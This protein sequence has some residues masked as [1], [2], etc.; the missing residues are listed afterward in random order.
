MLRQ[1]APLAKA[2]AGTLLATLLSLLINVASSDVMALK[3]WSNWAIWLL[4]LLLV[5][6]SLLL[7]GQRH[8]RSTQ[9]DEASA[10]ALDWV[11][12]LEGS[13]RKRMIVRVRSSWMTDV[14][15][16]SL[17]A[18][19]RAAA[20]ARHPAALDGP[21]TPWNLVHVQRGMA[22]AIPADTPVVEVFDRKVGGAMLI[23]G[24]PGAGKTTLLFRLASDLLDAA[25]VDPA[26]AVPVVFK[27]A[28]WSPPRSLDDWLV[29]ELHKLYDVPS[30]LGRHWV[31]TEQVMPLLHGLDEVPFQDRARCV[32]AVNAYRDRHGMTS[33]AVT[34]RSAAYEQAARRLRVQGTIRVDPPTP[35]QIAAYLDELGIQV[36]DIRAALD[37]D[38]SLQQVLAS[39]LALSV[40]ALAY[41]GRSG[42]DLVSGDPQDAWLRHLF[43]VYVERMLSRDDQSAGHARARYQREDVE[44]YLAWLA[45][46]LRRY[47]QGT[48]RL[49]WIQPQWLPTRAARF[50]A[51]WG[52]TLASALVATTIAGAV[53]HVIYGTLDPRLGLPKR[54]PLLGVAPWL[55]AAVAV[56]VAVGVFM[57]SKAVRPVDQLRWSWPALR[58]CLPGRMPMGV[59]LGVIAGM[60]AWSQGGIPQRGGGAV[61]GMATA[62][63]ALVLFITIGGFT[64]AMREDTTS[65]NDGMRRTRRTAVLASLPFALPFG[66]LTAVLYGM[67]FNPVIGLVAG[68]HTTVPFWIVAGLWAGGRDYL[69]HLSVRA[70]LWRA[71]LAPWHY[72]RF[73]DGVVECLLLE[74]VG[75][76]Y[77]FV[78]PLLL[79]HFAQRSERTARPGPPHRLGMV[80]R[81]L[82]RSFRV[83]ASE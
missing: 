14:F 63:I 59:L 64:G 40:V 22:E 74:Q 15:G 67:A 68:L 29:D 31:A 42:A 36:P 51:T 21:L 12:N 62:L 10:P 39:P 43:K 52:V 35:S 13:Y 77:Q 7:E 34:S 38:V 78:H 1:N 49:E 56:G 54:Q 32:E 5:V 3:R 83:V 44:R 30:N 79:E 48:F 2:F 53:A 60:V 66:L 26:S 71:R 19:A 28:S 33:L 58:D 45:R 6:L 50:A 16:G 25:E 20:S 8:R 41:R 61:V 82:A 11:P 18:A 73:L 57:H 9:P 4:I 27:L 81:R 72:A 75:P 37:D 23:L 46:V 55:V 70:L 47:P 76:G 24:G 69:R 17:G 80:G 65:P